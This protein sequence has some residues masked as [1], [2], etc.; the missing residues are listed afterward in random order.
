MS[1]SGSPLAYWLSVLVAALVG[2][3]LCV[4][5]RRH[6]G[7]WRSVASRVIAVVLLATF[8]TWEI[9]FFVRGDWSGGVSLPFSLCD[10]AALVTMGACWWRIPALV[11]L[12]YFWGFA[13]TL[14]AVITPDLAVPFPQLGFFEY[15]VEHLGILLAAAFLVIGWQLVPRPGAVRRVFAI[16]LAYTAFVGAMDALTGGDYM[17]LRSPPPY[18]SL[19][20]VLGPWPWYVLS[21]T[22]VALVL[23]IVLDAPF[24][25]GRARLDL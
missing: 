1:G 7:P 16:T 24:W 20:Q 22:A 19:L 17:F 11:E 6:P 23:L 5:A 12:A 8:A 21:A 4:Q 13:G 2:T 3:A 18:W 15:V 14:Q 25:R 9:G 10:M